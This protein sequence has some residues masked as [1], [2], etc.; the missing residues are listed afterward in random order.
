MSLGAVLTRVP[1]KQVITMLPSIVQTARGLLSAS[2]RQPAIPV[3]LADTPQGLALR[4]E[5][6]EENERIQADLVKRMAEQ[7][8]GL[9][10]GLQFLASRITALIW[11][12]AI[13]FILALASFIIA[14]V[15]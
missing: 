15:K 3:A 13:A 12:A 6:L 9:A 2:N 14:L 7:Q 11:I 1:W 10:E 5:Q 8:Q 4:V